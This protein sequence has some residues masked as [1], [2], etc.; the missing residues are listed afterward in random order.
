[1]KIWTIFA[2]LLALA[3]VAY[4]GNIQTENPHQGGIEFIL[5][6]DPGNLHVYVPARAPKSWHDVA[7]WGY[8]ETIYEANTVDTAGV[9]MPCEYGVVA[10]DPPSTFPVAPG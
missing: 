4:A 5:V 6:P 2:A 1:M 8:G 3:L 7:V 9:L 10:E